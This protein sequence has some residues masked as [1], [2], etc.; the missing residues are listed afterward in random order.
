MRMVTMKSA[1]VASALGALLLAA[2]PAPAWAHADVERT[3]PANGSQLRTAP[4]DVT[5]VFSEPVEVEAAH[6]TTAAGTSIPVRTR[7]AGA[8]VIITPSLALPAGAVAVDWTVKSDDGHVVSAA[9]GYWI[10]N[11]GSPGTSR[12]LATTPAVPARIR[13]TKPGPVTVTFNRNAT[14]DIE[15]SNAALPGPITWHVAPGKSWSS[16]S[17]VLP[18]PGAWTMTATLL[19]A[20]GSVLVTTATTSIGK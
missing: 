6:M 11:A 19:V 2:H 17:G 18:L 13:G 5:V 10:G 7:I 14:G 16:S 4:H 9:A 3:I 8:R 12:P 15:W 20:G 1:F